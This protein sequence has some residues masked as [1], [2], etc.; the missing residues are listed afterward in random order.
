[1]EI[2]AP[3]RLVVLPRLLVAIGFGALIWGVLELLDIV[4]VI[5]REGTGIV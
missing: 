3:F 1:V 5:N 2:N 4:D